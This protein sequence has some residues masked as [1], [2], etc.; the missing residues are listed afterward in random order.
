MT[1]VDETPGNNNPPTEIQLNNNTIAENSNNGTVVGSL[2]TTDSDNSDT[3]TYTLLNDSDGR[4]VVE[5]NRILV[6]NGSLLDFENNT[7]HTITVRTT[8]S[9]EPAESFEQQLTINV[10]DVDETPVDNNTVGTPGSDRLTGTNG[11]DTLTGFEGNDTYIINNSADIIIEDSNAGIDTA[12]S[13]ITYSLPGNVENLKLTGENIDGSGNP[14]NN[15]IVGSNG[16][17]KLR[18]GLGNDTLLGVGGADT[19]IGSNGNDILL[20]G[21]GDDI[22]QGRLGRDRLNGGAGNDTLTGGASI[23]RFIFNTNQPFQTEDIGTDT[24]TDFQEG[25]DKILLDKD[26]FTAINSLTGEGFSIV[27]EFE[28]VSSNAEARTA[29]GVI[30]YN[31]TNGNLF[32]NSNG[33]ANGFGEGGL[34][35]NV[36]NTP[37]LES[38]D[39]QIR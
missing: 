2:T 17:N 24:I 38:S 25:R 26:T 4:F 8:D 9:G 23:D 6:G 14:R 22:L 21:A 31:Q 28:V 36:A 27:E 1:D 20:G 18:G 13:S 7:S 35:A 37:E 34:F 39:F 32:Y 30:V 33:V 11:G 15:Y 10:T 29:V 12:E 16:D 3:H 19:V 5:G